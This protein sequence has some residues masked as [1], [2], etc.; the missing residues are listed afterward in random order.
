[1]SLAGEQEAALTVRT[2]GSRYVEL[3]SLRGVAAL[4]VLAYHYSNA[5]PAAAS[6]WLRPFLAG[7]QAVILF[8]VLSGFVLSLPFWNKGGN[9]PYRAYI[10]RRIF[11]IYVP[12]LAAVA[13][14]AIGAAAFYG[15]RLPL[16]GWFADTWRTPVT[17]GLLGKAVLMDTRPVLNTAFWSLRYEMIMSLVFPLLLVGLRWM[18]SV[19]AA[20]FMVAMVAV[21]VFLR[22][23]SGMT[24]FEETI[25]YGVFFILGAVLANKR[26]TLRRWL[27]DRPMGVRLL[28]LLVAVLL[29][30]GYANDLAAMWHVRIPNDDLSG[31]GAAGLIVVA[32]S[33]RRLRDVLRKPGLEYVGRISYSLYLIHGTVLFAVLDAGYGKA[34]N[35]ILCLVFAI[36]TWGLSHLFCIGVEEP[37]LRLG[38]RLSVRV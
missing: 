15:V 32:M 9:G 29:Y 13:L 3:D 4:T 34:P 31:L 24:A 20:V 38:K 28:L 35:W 5:F 14:A 16:S 21:S 30:L 1:M 8:F 12:Y 11:R 6:P 36:V 7:H 27:N 25:H 37:S 2:S 23:R 33:A 22:A 10:V 19:G 26:E 17:V 18:R